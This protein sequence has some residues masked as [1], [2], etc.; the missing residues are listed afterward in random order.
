M[1]ETKWEQL[2][3]GRDRERSGVGKKE[4]GG[5][6]RTSNLTAFDFE[7]FMILNFLITRILNDNNSDYCY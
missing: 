4:A 6:S 7:F 5:G 2:S 1:V 3:V